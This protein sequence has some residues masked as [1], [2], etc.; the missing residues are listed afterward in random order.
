MTFCFNFILFIKLSYL[1]KNMKK[2]LT[3]EILLKKHNSFGAAHISFNV[4][5][6][7]TELNMVTSW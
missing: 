3:E 5:A 6:S 2:K 7:I 1:Y 4:Q